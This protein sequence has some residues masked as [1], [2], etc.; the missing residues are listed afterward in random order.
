MDVNMDDEMV[1]M[2]E[3]E[4]IMVDESKPDSMT[5]QVLQD[6]ANRLRIRSIQATCALS[7]G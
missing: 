6:L 3:V 7:Y 1:A 2:E 5:L 4:A